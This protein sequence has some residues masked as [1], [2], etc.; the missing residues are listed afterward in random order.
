MPRG[1]DL[2][3]QF[4]PDISNRAVHHNQATKLSFSKMLS[5]IFF[6]SFTCL[7]LSLLLANIAAS[8]PT[9]QDEPQLLS[10][11][12]I[13][14]D[15]DDIFSLPLVLSGENSTL[16]TRALECKIGYSECAYDTSRCCRIGGKCCGN[17]YCASIGDTC[18]AGGGTCPLGYKCCGTTGC[19]PLGA[20]CCSGGYYCRVGRTCRIYRGEKVC[21]AL[22]GCA[23]EYD[24][25]AAG[26]TLTATE[27]ETATATTTATAGYVAVDWDYY[28]T[29]VYWY[30]V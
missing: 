21:C 20:Q 7:A 10:N 25:V 4:H 14:F 30:V 26:A 17:G 1:S 23:G 29:T 16:N 9:D 6:P 28:Y 24:G 3:S 15:A 12:S 2:K 22:T 8:T 19:A 11:I 27:V 18:C 13:S 5:P